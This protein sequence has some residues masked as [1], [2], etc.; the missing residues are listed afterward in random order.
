MNLIFNDVALLPVYFSFKSGFDTNLILILETS[1][2]S[3]K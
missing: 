3:N 2:V 1:K